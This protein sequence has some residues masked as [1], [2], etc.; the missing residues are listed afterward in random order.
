MAELATLAGNSL[1]TSCLVSSVACDDSVFLLLL[2][3]GSL[4][5]GTDSEYWEC[6]CL[7]LVTNPKTSRSRWV[8]STIKPET[9]ARRSRPPLFR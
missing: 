8:L 6:N 5:S 9:I 1:T 2:V 7:Q 3:D 4:L